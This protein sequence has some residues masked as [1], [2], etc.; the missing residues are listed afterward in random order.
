MSDGIQGNDAR[1]ATFVAGIPP[2]RP[3]EPQGV[4]DVLAILASDDAGFVSALNLPVNGELSAL[5][6]HPPQA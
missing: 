5:N 4:G 1:P 6:R 2:G 3:A